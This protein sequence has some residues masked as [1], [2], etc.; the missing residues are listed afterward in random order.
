MKG[1]LRL[2]GLCCIPAIL[3]LFPAN[4]AASLFSHAGRLC[5]HLPEEKESQTQGDVMIASSAFSPQ[6]LFAV[7]AKFH[8]RT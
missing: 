8:S 1:T 7:C 2:H 4:Q 5:R 3:L 6:H